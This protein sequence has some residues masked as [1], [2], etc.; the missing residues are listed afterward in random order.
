MPFVVNFV[1][2]IKLPQS[3]TLQN[4]NLIQLQIL[5]SSTQ[6]MHYNIEQ[7]LILK[8]FFWSKLFFKIVI[9]FIINFCRN[10][11]KKN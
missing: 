6:Q 7:G 1:M 5:T 11:N 9:I 2:N 4:T 3:S 8:W 10:D